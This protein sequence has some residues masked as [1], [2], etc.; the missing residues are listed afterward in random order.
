MKVD[1]IIPCYNAEN[2]IEASIESALSQT[3]ENTQVIV[4]DNESTDSSYEIVKRLHSQNPE[5]I[6][7]SAPNLYPYGWTE[8]VEKALSLCDGDYFT[9][10][11]ADDYVD[12]SYVDN[13]VKILSTA[14]D[15]IKVLQS[16]IVGVDSDKGILLEEIKHSYANLEQF[17]QLLFQR[18]PVTTPT[19]VYKRELHDMG[20]VRWDSETWSGA[21]D[22]DLYFNIADHG[23]FIYPYPQWIGYHYRWHADQATWGMHKQTTNYDLL[24]QQKWR[25]KWKNER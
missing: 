8:P 10:L 12:S 11:G 1:I 16:P 23:I 21:A 4:I 2:W 14:P 13:I 5:M 22:Y 25:E 20:I 24:I 19:V 15:K 18:C 3:Y 9:I 6:I 17:K 7:G